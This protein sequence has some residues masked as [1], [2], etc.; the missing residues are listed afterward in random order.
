MKSIEID[1]ISYRFSLDFRG[2]SWNVYLIAL[3]QA[4]SSL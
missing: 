3:E 1:L 4:M 2:R